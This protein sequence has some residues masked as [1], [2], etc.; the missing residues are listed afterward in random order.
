MKKICQKFNILPSFAEKLSLYERELSVRQQE[1][2]Y[3]KVG[4]EEFPLLLSLVWIANQERK[5]LVLTDHDPNERN[6]AKLNSEQ[7]IK[8]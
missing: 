4:K 7:V 5:G 1:I 8:L 3:R 6:Y 2:F